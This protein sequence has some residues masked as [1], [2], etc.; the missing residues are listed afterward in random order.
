MVIS[1][2]LN[3]SQEDDLLGI[4]RKCKQAIGWKI[5]YLKGIS[6]LVSNHHIYIKEEAKSVHKDD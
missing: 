3:V 6:P 1:S 4:H 2:S 5:S